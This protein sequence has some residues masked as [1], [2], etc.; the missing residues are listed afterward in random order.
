MWSTRRCSSSRSVRGSA[1]PRK[2][3]RY[4]S[5]NACVARSESDCGSVCGKF[6][7][8]FPCRWCKRRS[9]CSVSTLRLQPSSRA[10]ATYHSRVSRSDT[11]SR[12]TQ[13]WNHGIC[14][15]AC[16]TIARSGQA[17]AKA[18]MYL[19]LRGENP[20]MSGNASRRSCERRS[21]VPASPAFP[22]L[23]GKNRPAD[24]PV[25]QHHRL[26]GGQ[27]NAHAFR[28]DALLDLTEQGRVVSGQLSPARRC[29]DRSVRALAPHGLPFRH[30]PRASKFRLM[31][32]C[33]LDGLCVELIEFRVDIPHRLLEVEILVFFLR[34]DADIASR[35][36]APTVGGQFVVAN[37]LHHQPF[38]VSQGR[39][40]GTAPEASAPAARSNAAL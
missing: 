19:R 10:F 29:G 40:R 26:V 17:A 25:E 21:M 36:Q 4:G 8:A 14:A 33:E 11:L 2:S 15:A 6:V 16:C 22:L 39:V 24:V 37:Q 31:L 30:G 7:I 12:R 9:I 13:L 18:R 5:L 1:V 32:R 27:H 28:A 35:R 20:R 34:R 23:A 3:N 38:D